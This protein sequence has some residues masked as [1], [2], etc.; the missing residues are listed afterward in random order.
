MTWAIIKQPHPLDAIW[1][2]AC[3]DLD[4]ANELASGSEEATT[5][6]IMAIMA[7]PARNLADSLYKLDCAGIDRP[8]PRTDCNLQAIMDEACTLTDA[9]IALGQRRFPHQNRE[10]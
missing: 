8:S 1:S 7:L 5:A 2:R 3:E 9:A 10:A 4:D 6:A